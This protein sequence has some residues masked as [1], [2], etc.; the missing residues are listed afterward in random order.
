M[1]KMMLWTLTALLQA[2]LLVGPLFP[3]PAGAP[4]DGF[5]GLLYRQG[6][7]KSEL[8]FT[9]KATRRPDLWVDQYS[10]A[11]GNVAVTERV[12]LENG[13]PLRYEFD[14]R[15]QK[16][17]GSVEVRGRTLRLTWIQGGSTVE[18][19]VAAPDDL[20]FGPLYPT[21]LQRRL[22]DLVAGG[23]VLATV[24]VLSQSHLMT[25]HLSFQ[26]KKALEKEGGPI[27]ISMRP[28][29]WF[30][31]LFFPPIVLWLDAKTGQLLEVHGVSL[32]KERLHEDWKM[33]AVDLYYQY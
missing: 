5:S 18:K 20:V 31:S 32:L 26:R 19:T 28:S 22:S 2:S 12:L 10:D 29:N 25:A 3:D 7:Q 30:V 23:T 6:S 21:L 9:L 27:C 17:L 11:Q 16:G 8:L 24:P 1:K 4:Q 15:Q 33:T 14:D 13:H